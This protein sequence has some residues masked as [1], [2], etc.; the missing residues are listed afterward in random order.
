MTRILQREPERFINNAD[1]QNAPV[2]VQQLQRCSS[3]PATPL[4]R[5]RGRRPIR[6]VKKRAIKN[7]TPDQAKEYL[8]EQSLIRQAKRKRAWAEE[9]AEEKKVILSIQD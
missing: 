3:L 6:K 8:K 9:L 1:N 2:R 7:M 5:G 4:K